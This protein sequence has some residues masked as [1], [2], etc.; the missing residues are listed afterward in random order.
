MISSGGRWLEVAILAGG[1][2]ES[3]WKTTT[4]GLLLLVLLGRGV[5]RR[6]RE[7][8]RESVLNLLGANEA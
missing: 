1:W 5:E 6:R 2:P 8:E 4:E 7:E 3:G